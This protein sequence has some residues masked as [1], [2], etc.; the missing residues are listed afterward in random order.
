MA[1]FRNVEGWGFCCLVVVLTAGCG[2]LRPPDL[3]SAFTA[4]WGEKPDR[5]PGLKSPAEKIASLQEL[6][7]TADAADSARHHAVAEQLAEMI[8]DE[9]D[10]VIRAEIVRTLSHYRAEQA[11][12]VLRRALKD[13]DA[14]VRVAAC[15]AWAEREHPDSSKILAEVLSTDLDVDVRLAAARALGETDDPAAVQAL[16]LALDDRDPAMQY[17]A[18]QSLR[19]VTGEDL[20]ND[21]ERWRQYV[22]GE[23]PQTRREI[24]I[25]ERLQSFF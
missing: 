20:G 3:G 1:G 12:R 23:K 5:V 10:P 22:R 7:D 13:S 8:R 17:R 14:D 21:L 6:A 4:P 19:E 18:V 16:G 11:D 25:A 9:P 15:E 2:G 24:S